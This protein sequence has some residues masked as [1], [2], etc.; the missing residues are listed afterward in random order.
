MGGKQERKGKRVCACGSEL[1]GGG[2]KIPSP[3]KTFQVV[4]VQRHVGYC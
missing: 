3:T 1:L 2:W 4:V